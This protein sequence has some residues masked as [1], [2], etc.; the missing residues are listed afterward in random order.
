MLALLVASRVG[1]AAQAPRISK[2]R[3][4]PPSVSTMP[5]LRPAIIDDTLAIGGQDVKAR[6][7]ETRLTVEVHINGHGPYQFVVDSGA[8]TSVVGWRIARD[9]QLPLGTPALLNGMTDRSIVDRVR[10]DSLTLG[11]TTIQDL[12]LPTL[13]EGDVGGQGMIGI[14]ALVRQ[15]IMMDFEKRLIKVEDATRPPKALPDEIVIIARRSRG[16]L[17]LTHVRASGLSLDAVIDTG[18]EMTI[19]N[20]ILRDKLIRRRQKFQQVK[21]IGVTGKEID[22]QVAVIPELQIGGILIRNLPVAFADLP[23]FHVFGIADEPALFLGTD[24]L[25]TFR[26]VS[27]DFQARKVRFQLKRCS[28][29]GILIQTSPVYGST[30]LSSVS[31]D[32]CAQ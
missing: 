10:V 24:V 3:P 15:R 25:E 2:P 13:R 19:G 23:P 4:A 1:V 14:D 27:L 5:P 29:A 12:Q 17:I 26:K 31:T 6:Q 18:A 32:V 28:T 21:A 16:Q 22:L 11:P 9:L 8:D 7:V 20:P 30:R